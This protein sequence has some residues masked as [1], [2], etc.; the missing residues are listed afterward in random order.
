M[1]LK[2]IFSKL[3][4]QN[5]Y[6]SLAVFAETLEKSGEYKIADK[7]INYVK[8]ANI[9]TAQFQ[10]KY[11]YDTI[12][13]ELKQKFIEI[14]NSKLENP[15]TID[16]FPNIED[17]I[18][19]MV[20]S[21]KQFNALG[22]QILSHRYK[23]PEDSAKRYLSKFY[24]E[25]TRS[26]SNKIPNFQD[27][28]KFLKIIEDVFIEKGIDTSSLS[29]LD[30][31]DKNFYY[32]FSPKSPI[33][34]E[35]FNRAKAE[36]GD[37]FESVLEKIHLDKKHYE[38]TK[39]QRKKAFQ[40]NE[41][42]RGFG[43]K[44]TTE[45]EILKNAIIY[46][47]FNPNFIIDP[48]KPD[49]KRFF[50]NKDAKSIVFRYIDHELKKLGSIK[51]SEG[52]LLY[53][54]YYD[55]Q[56]ATAEARRLYRSL[57][58]VYD[59][60]V[61]RYDAW[62]AN[63]TQ[64]EIGKID[65]EDKD[66]LEREKIGKDWTEEMKKRRENIEKDLAGKN[67]NKK[68]YEFWKKSLIEYEMIK[69]AH[70]HED[71]ENVARQVAEMDPYDPDQHFTLLSKLKKYEPWNWENQLDAIGNLAAPHSHYNSIYPQTYIY[72]STSM[73][74][75]RYLY[76][77]PKQLK[78][79]EN[80]D[81]HEKLSTPFSIDTPISDVYQWIHKKYPHASIDHFSSEEEMLD[82]EM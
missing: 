11:N 2:N 32:T 24:K 36:I 37:K 12:N 21:R 39:E 67:T 20:D 19:I 71:I 46:S 73:G 57:R 81:Y 5:D 25:I 64:N 18:P 78:K 82:Q 68:W 74:I 3:A 61:V 65:S 63:K 58:D 51:N 34:N 8:F 35:I 54:G 17:I 56:S 48:S 28:V 53:P 15:T 40:T 10:K 43:I 16:N 38:D 1:D 4:E 60:N 70:T 23:M 80:P 42:K 29:A 22:M 50:A 62:W 77:D 7:V 13:S 72:P 14:V 9:K 59:Y 6:R 52:K 76:F 33:R 30:P 41:Q 45:L 47:G 44:S 79:L 31:S 26:I 27:I 49:S 69:I 75:W 66:R 55:D